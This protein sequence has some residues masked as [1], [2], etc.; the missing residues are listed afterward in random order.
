M[1]DNLNNSD[2]FV[3]PE[4]QVGETDE[5]ILR[6]IV[7]FENTKLK[8][9]EIQGQIKNLESTNDIFAGDKE[10]RALKKRL[11]DIQDRYRLNPFVVEK[12]SQ[13][14]SKYKQFGGKI[15]LNTFESDEISKIKVLPRLSINIP[16]QHKEVENTEEVKE[17]IKPES[18]IDVINKM[19]SEE[20]SLKSKVCITAKIKRSPEGARKKFKNKTYTTQLPLEIAGIFSTI[21]ESHITYPEAK[22]KKHKGFDFNGWRDEQE[23]RKHIKLTQTDITPHDSSFQFQQTNNEDVKP[24]TFKSFDKII[25]PFFTAT[26]H[27]STTKTNMQRFMIRRC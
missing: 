22:I 2:G 12:D 5:I 23:K 6:H 24:V 20:K 9:T 7:E 16:K 17:N 27:S 1:I 26:D 19:L 25:K 18:Q 3:M 4:I 13:F 15:E 21:T 10:K 8:E 11:K 14:F